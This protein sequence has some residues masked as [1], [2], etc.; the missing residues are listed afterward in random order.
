MVLFSSFSHF[1]SFLILQSISVF[2]HCLVHLFS[3]S[4]F[5]FIST[6]FLTALFKFYFVEWCWLLRL[7]LD[8]IITFS[9]G[10]RV[11]F[12][13]LIISFE[14]IFFNQEKFF[15]DTYTTKTLLIP[16]V[17]YFS[18]FLSS[19]V[20]GVKIVYFLSLIFFFTCSLNFEKPYSSVWK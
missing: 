7:L 1:V 15:L 17:S 4:K 13:F 10:L 3:V 20:Q 14:T 6:L 19:W 12:F 5:R 8:R 9:F 16:N 18:S 11:N 2:T